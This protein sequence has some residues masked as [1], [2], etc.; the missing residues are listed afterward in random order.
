ML[1]GLLGNN[2]KLIQNG[3]QKMPF[4]LLSQAG[5]K[6]LVVPA[7]PHMHQDFF[8]LLSCFGFSGAGNRLV[9]LWYSS[10]RNA[11]RSDW[12]FYLYVFQIPQRYIQAAEFLLMKK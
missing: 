8:F 3:F 9:Y 7:S 11:T 1:E 4:F 6:T 12:K 10:K 2:L 5:R